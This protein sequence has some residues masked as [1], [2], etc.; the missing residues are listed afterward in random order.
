MSG[1]PLRGLAL[2]L[3]VAALWAWTG[4][5]RGA[6]CQRYEPDLVDL[7]GD[8][9]LTVFPGPPHYRSVETGDQPEAVWMLQLAKP[10]CIEAIADD[11]WNVARDGVQTIEV[12]PRTA[13]PVSLNGKPVQLQGTLFRARGGHRH[14]EI[15]LRATLAAP[16]K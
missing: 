1:T 9:Q 6:Q 4:A 7:K 12:I 3:A 10:I 5:A 16:A 8:L 2:L 11:P 14:A 15:V 13:F